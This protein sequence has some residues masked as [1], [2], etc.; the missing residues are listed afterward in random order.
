[1]R[2][3]LVHKSSDSLLDALQPLFDTWVDGRKQRFSIEKQ[4]SF[5]VQFI[6]EDG[7]HYTINQ[8]AAVIEFRHRWRVRPRSGSLPV[9]ELMSKAQ[10]YTELLSQAAEKVLD[11]ATLVNGSRARVLHRI[12][13]V[14][15]TVVGHKEVPPGIKRLIS[16]MSKPWGGNVPQYN[17]E[18][19][20]EIGEQHDYADRCIHSVGM[21]DENNPDRLITV[22]LDWQRVFTIVRPITMDVIKKHVATAQKSALDYFEDVAEGSRFDEEILNKSA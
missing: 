3:G 17:I 6:T 2:F 12:G 4:D 8:E 22:K 5:G 9:A 13:I 16:F 20:G 18:I 14:T 19:T 21:G 7:F 1:L 10:P 11:A 15:N